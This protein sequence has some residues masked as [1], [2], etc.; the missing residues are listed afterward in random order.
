LVKKLVDEFSDLIHSK[1]EDTRF[2]LINVVAGQCLR[3]L[4]KLGMRDEIDRFLTKLH[5]EVL[6]GA[7][8]AELKRK[9]ASKPEMWGA[10]LQ[11]LLNLAGGWLTYNWNDRAEPILVEARS[12]LLGTSAVKLPPKDY[13]ELARA[14]VTALGHGGDS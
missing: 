14:Y 5:N 10:V 2:K 6:R 1:P 11:T 13:T 9:H 4:K 8:T 7:T 3:S 12:E